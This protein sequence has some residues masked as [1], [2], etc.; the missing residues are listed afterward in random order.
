QIGY[1]G[2]SICP[3]PSRI[4]T[5]GIGYGDGYPRHARNG[6]PVWL[7]GQRAAL[8]G[9]VSMDSITVDITAVGGVCVGDEAE[10]WGKNLPAAEIAA[11]AETISYE[12]F[13]SIGQ[14]VVREYA[15]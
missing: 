13:T 14:R 10:L 5:I 4:A 6:T 11:C 9:R 8:A 2:I 7:R 15:E 3:R 12:L 1:N